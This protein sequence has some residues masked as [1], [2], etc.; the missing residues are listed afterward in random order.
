M[1]SGGNVATG[2]LQCESIS[3]SFDGVEALRDV[4]INFPAYGVVAVIGPNGAGK[5][6]LIN[7]LSGF[8]RPDSGS[9]WLNGL[10]ITD[11]LPYKIARQGVVRTFQDVRIASEMSVLDNVMLACA[12]PRSTAW[13][14]DLI[15]NTIRAREQVIRRSAEE[16]LRFAQLHD[17]LSRRAGD[18]SYGQRKL[19]TLACCFASGAGTLLL[20]EP[21]AGV[22]PEMALQIATVL[23][24][25][26]KCGKHIVFIEHDIACVRR[27]ADEVIV[28]AEGK[29]IARGETAEVLARH[30]VMEAYLD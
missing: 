7:V 10:E 11:W 19:L 15:P 2:Q 20:D 12:H 14:S 18:L 23:R 29:V 16:A 8:T 27:L 28:L 30:E 26:S 9:V 25:M 5:T 24:E 3:K 1:N 17:E 22:Y 6:T 4:T 21:I 13:F